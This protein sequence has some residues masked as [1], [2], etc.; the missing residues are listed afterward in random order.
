MVPRDVKSENDKGKG[1]FISTIR[2]IELNTFLTD[3]KSII[4]YST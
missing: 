3:A 1:K 4:P 2:Q